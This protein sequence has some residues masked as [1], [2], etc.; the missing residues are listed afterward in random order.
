MDG[1]GIRD[2]ASRTMPLRAVPRPA[3]PAPAPV[4]RVRLVRESKL[5]LLADGAV[6]ADPEPLLPPGH[7]AVGPESGLGAVV[8]RGPGADRAAAGERRIVW[9][10]VLAV[11]LALVLGEILWR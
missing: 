4:P 5:P 2:G 7:G 1:T 9:W 11:G 3:T 10:V 6:D 8:L